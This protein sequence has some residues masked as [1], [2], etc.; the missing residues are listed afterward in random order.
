MYRNEIQS[1][2]PYY[3]KRF[4][5]DDDTTNKKANKMAY[6]IFSMEENFT[7]N[8]DL[9]VT[10]D[11]DLMYNR[12]KRAVGLEAE[13]AAENEAARRKR[14]KK[15]KVRIKI[16]ANVNDADTSAK[17][18]LSEFSF[19]EEMRKLE[20]DNKF[21]LS[22]ITDGVHFDGPADAGDDESAELA[23]LTIAV[24]VRTHERVVKTTSPNPL[25]NADDAGKNLRPSPP[26]HDEDSSYN[27]S[28]YFPKGEEAVVEAK[29]Q[30]EEASSSSEI[31]TEKIADPQT[32]PEKDMSMPDFIPLSGDGEGED[33]QL[34]NV[35]VGSLVSLFYLL[36]NS[37]LFFQNAFF[38]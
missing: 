32:E 2:T 15:S 12:F 8:Y 14:K 13:E 4:T 17:S 19:S 31:V 38:S 23:E 11:P 33:I 18:T 30:P 1:H 25:S 26:G 6:A 9:N 21:E 7:F 29:D 34:T 20:G 16:G 22:F 3:P 27:F 5:N 35:V 36:L 24:D 10:S 28:E 37:M